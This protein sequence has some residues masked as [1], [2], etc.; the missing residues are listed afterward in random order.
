[1]SNK[2]RFSKDLVS[3]V[4]SN[5][6]ILFSSV[7]T[8]FII[9]KI[10]G[11]FEYGLYKIFTLYLSYSALAHMGFVDGILLRFAGFE[12]VNLPKNK[13]RTFTR[14]FFIFQCIIGVGIIVFAHVFLKHEYVAIISLLGIDLIAVN[15]TAYYQYISQGTMRFKELSFRKILLA[16][17]K[18]ALVLSLLLLY[19]IGLTSF[20]NA[21][22]YVSGLVLI[23]VC[24]LV[25][26]FFSYKDISWG[27]R[28]A[29]KSVQTE[30][31]KIFKNGIIL[32]IAFQ[33]AAF[34]FTIDMQFVS[35]LFDTKIYG[36][37]SFA[38]SIISMVTTVVGAV[39][40]VLFPR[41]KQLTEERIMDTFSDAMMAV[42][43]VAV[44]A[45]IG[46]QPLVLIIHSFLPDYINSIPYLQ[47]VFPGLA[48]SC[49]INIVM[50]TYYKALNKHLLYFLNCCGVLVIAVVLNALAYY[51]Y[52][53]P[54]Y[55]SIASIITLIVWYIICESYFIRK[56]SVS[57]KKN[58]IYVF[59]SMTAF[60]L[61]S[62]SI[63]NELIGLILY[64]SFFV[65]I[66][67]TFYWKNILRLIKAH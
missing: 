10:L 15:M 2:S 55:I 51:F 34:V 8:G 7:I 67:W 50:F 33:T 46:F 11:V 57:W 12:Y 52:R 24:L 23:D 53:N 59:L 47:I 37:Y 21:T 20:V 1:M 64:I 44:A 29:I 61:I 65:F 36:T 13:M 31:I 28:V 27:E 60:Y 32:T 4:T 22:S 58:M 26:Y 49:C 38:Y 19:K 14:F 6:L 39:A 42:S 48:M 43:I 5:I 16:V 3:V 25:W 63:K 45:M 41:L 40:L 54:E 30:I 18:I 56:Y 35:V 17:F 9:P 66:T 62:F